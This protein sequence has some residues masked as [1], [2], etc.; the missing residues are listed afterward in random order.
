MRWLAAALAFLALLTATLPAAAAPKVEL[1]TMG[2]GND[3]FARYGHSV[4]CLREGETKPARCFDYGVPNG[5]SEFDVAWNAVRG[6]ATFIPVDAE[7]PNVIAFFKDQG[8][9]VE[10]QKLPL[11]DAEAERL[12]ALLDRDVQEKRA[13][14]YHPYYANC[15]TMIRDR[16]DEATNGRLRPGR[17]LPVAVRF[18]DLAEEGHTGHAGELL[19]M[20]ITLGAPNERLPTSWEAMFLPRIL[21]EAVT[22]RFDAQPERVEE[23]LWTN[24]PA[25]R[26]AGRVLLFVIAFALVFAVR[27][28]GWRGRPRAARFLVGGVLGTLGTI[29]WAAS[30]LVV[31]PEIQRNWALLLLFPFDFAIPFLAPRKLAIYGKVRITMAVALAVLE[32]AGVVSQPMLPI[33]ALVF[34]P[35]VALL[36]EK[37]R[38]PSPAPE[39]AAVG[40]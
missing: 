38:V 39:P 27:L 34:M 6:V 24:L 23:R 10:R 22:E 40:V 25:S 30:A 33:A 7:E 20:A 37:S 15:T 5:R 29:A 28:L 17:S 9:S 13:Y 8:R 1:L 31:W 21:K 32:L 18:R 26:A 12:A 4:V 36:R 14:A 3:L 2:E 35:L 16:I 19:L 11:T